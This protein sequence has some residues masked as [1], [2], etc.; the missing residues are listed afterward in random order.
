MISF[1]SY[2]LFRMI[3]AIFLA[4]KGG[5]ALPICV[6]A[7]VRLAPSF[8]PSKKKSSGKD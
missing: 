8:V 4:I 5:T 6:K 7:E 1:V 2:I 3:V